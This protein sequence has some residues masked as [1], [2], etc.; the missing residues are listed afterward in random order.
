MLSQLLRSKDPQ[1]RQ[2]G[3]AITQLEY[4]NLMTALKLALS[5]QVSITGPYDALIVYLN[6]RKDHRRKL[7]HPHIMLFNKLIRVIS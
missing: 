3:Q 5:A 1:E 2:V 4:E 6:E 7:A